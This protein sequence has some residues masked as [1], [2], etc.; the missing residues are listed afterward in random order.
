[1]IK[2]LIVDD[3]PFIR[4]YMRNLLAQDSGIRVIGEAENG[5]DALEKVTALQPD[6]LTMDLEMPEMDGLRATREIMQQ[7]PRPIIMVSAFTREDT[8]STIRALQLGAV[9]F[10]S[11]STTYLG[12]DIA[13]IETELKRKIHE[14]ASCSA[15]EREKRRMGNLAR[16]EQIRKQLGAAVHG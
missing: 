6:L 7:S 11:K 12:L 1:M 14:W 13:H 3:D 2:L 10:I 16:L 5:R 8:E 9:D 4:I 15:E